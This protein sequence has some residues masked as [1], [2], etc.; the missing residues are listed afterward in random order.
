MPLLELIQVRLHDREAFGI[1]SHL[2]V[3]L[4]CDRDDDVH[5]IWEATAAA[6]HFSQLVVD[7]GGNDELPGIVVEEAPDDRFHVLRRDD[8]ALADE[9]AQA[10][11]TPGSARKTGRSV[12]FVAIVSCRP[13]VKVPVTGRLSLAAKLNVNVS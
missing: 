3:I 12:K 6:A 8:V 1:G 13:G 2:E 9:H 10:S 4:F 5:H 11:G 7:L